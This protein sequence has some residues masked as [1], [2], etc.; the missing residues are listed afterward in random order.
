MQDVSWLPWHA[1]RGRQEKAMGSPGPVRRARRRTD[2]QPSAWP[3]PAAAERLATTCRRRTPGHY[4]PELA[5]PLGRLP[6]A[7]REPEPW[8]PPKRRDRRWRRRRRGGPGRTS[9]CCTRSG[10]ARPRPAPPPTSSIRR[11]RPRGSRCPARVS[12]T[13][14]YRIRAQAV[15]TYCCRRVGARRRSNPLS[16]SSAPP[17]TQETVGSPQRHRCAV[18]A[19]QE[20]VASPQ[21]HMCAVAASRG[22]RGRRARSLDSRP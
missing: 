18:A 3:L 21:R 7:R 11:R 17:A 1:F 15:P 5:G 14:A 12:A 2:E 19:T 6:V 20:T 13:T 8:Q 16:P 22:G 10:R 4:L 9:P